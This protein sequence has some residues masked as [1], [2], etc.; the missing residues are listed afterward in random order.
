MNI[1]AIFQMYG[2]CGAR[3]RKEYERWKLNNKSFEWWTRKKNWYPFFN[4]SLVFLVFFLYYS[5]GNLSVLNKLRLVEERFVSYLHF[6]LVAS[7]GA[8]PRLL[9]PWSCFLSLLM[10]PSVYVCYCC[11][12]CLDLSGWEN[13]PI[14]TA[15]R[16][17]NGNIESEATITWHE[18]EIHM[19]FHPIEKSKP[20]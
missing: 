4:F 1:A 16:C 11:C 18:R 5:D 12:C 2:W 14:K 10:P 17:V 20:A 19:N 7:A 15:A 8:H 9:R 6:I 3:I 13:Q